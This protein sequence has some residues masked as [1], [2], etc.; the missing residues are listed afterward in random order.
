MCQH[1]KSRGERFHVTS[2]DSIVLLTVQLMTS[3]SSVKDGQLTV[4]GNCVVVWIC[5]IKVAMFS[6]VFT[7]CTNLV[8]KVVFVTVLQ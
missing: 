6:L 1:G 5:F 3:L 8:A 2:R 4:Q 7:Y